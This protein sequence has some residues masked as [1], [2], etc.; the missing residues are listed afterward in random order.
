MRTN[1]AKTNKK[2]LIFLRYI[3]YVKNLVMFCVD[4]IMRHE[5]SLDTSLAQPLTR[6][7]T[8]DR[9]LNISA[10]QLPHFHLEILF[11]LP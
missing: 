2:T 5:D 9:L 1:K 7:V 6:C 10:P 3:K 8:M 4:L 11:S